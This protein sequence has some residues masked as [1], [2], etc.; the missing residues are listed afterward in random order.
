[1]SGDDRIECIRAVALFGRNIE[2]DQGEVSER[3]ASFTEKPV[4]VI[5]WCRHCDGSGSIAD[6]SLSRG[7]R[8]Q[9]FAEV[10]AFIIKE[11][12]YHNPSIGSDA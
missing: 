6:G 1:M 3:N 7:R 9:A 4:E 10:C 2:S 11:R 12:Q 5:Q 8:E